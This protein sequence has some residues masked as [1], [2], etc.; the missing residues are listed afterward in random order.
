MTQPPAPDWST[1]L[2]LSVAREVRRHR[3]SQGLSAQQLADRCTEV[4][5]PIQRSVLANLESGRRTTVTIAEVLV[6][7]AA[8]NVPPAA[9]VFPVGRTD[10]V[11][12]LPGKE[13]DPLNAVEWFSGVRSIDSKVPFSRNALFLYRRHRALVKDLR[14]RLAQREELRAHYARADDAIAAE[15]LQAATEHLIQAQAEEA[16]AQDRLDRAISEG[17]E[18]SLPR[19]HLLRSVVA[20]NEAMAERRRAEMEAG[21]ATYIKMS[22][23]SADELIRER[24]MDLEKARIDMRDWG[25]LLPRLRDDLHGIVRELP[26]AEVSGVLADGPLGVEGE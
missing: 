19:A 20:V 18:S 9:L 1:R 15:R 5:M 2:A 4:G 23:D 10:V 21:N 24:A 26:E 6:L 11:E 8:L 7:A 13:I 22:L 3:Q 16:A 25:L 17:D 12:A 14:A